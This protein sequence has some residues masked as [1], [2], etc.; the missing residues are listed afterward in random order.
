MQRI[1]S[2]DPPGKGKPVLVTGGSGFIATWIVIQL[3]QRG[4][5]VR[6]TVRNLAREAAVRAAIA[7]QADTGQLSFYAA[8]LLNDSGW[9]AAAESAAST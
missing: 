3:L 9:E 4:Y 2:T 7:R 5:T 8:D 6:T 1:L